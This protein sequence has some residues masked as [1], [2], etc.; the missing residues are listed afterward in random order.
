MTGRSVTDRMRA[1]P[2]GS[3]VGVEGGVPLTGGVLTVGDSPPPPPPPQAVRMTTASAMAES[4]AS[5]LKAVLVDLERVLPRGSKF[6]ATF[7]A[8]SLPP[9]CGA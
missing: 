3:G 8:I 4:L 6:L 2:T 9:G 1:L 5:G 7:I